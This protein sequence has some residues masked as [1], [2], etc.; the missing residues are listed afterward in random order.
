MQNEFFNTLSF[1]GA[2][3]NKIGLDAVYFTQK[4]LH[5]CLDL[6]AGNC[7]DRQCNRRKTSQAKQ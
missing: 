2:Q 5:H 4:P 3:S 1:K 7:I 6:L